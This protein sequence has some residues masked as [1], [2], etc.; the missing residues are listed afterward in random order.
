MQQFDTE[1]SKY[2]RLANIPVISSVRL[3]LAP[4]GTASANSVEDMN[5]NRANAKQVLEFVDAILD[6]LGDRY[7]TII[8]ALYIQGL[9][10]WQVY[11]RLGYG[12]SRYGVLKNEACA[13]FAQTMDMTAG[14]QLT[15]YKN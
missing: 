15:A 3:S 14:T 9:Q 11:E 13:L 2:Q 4:K 12:R 1:Y 6:T 10:N 8:K 5:V 7:K